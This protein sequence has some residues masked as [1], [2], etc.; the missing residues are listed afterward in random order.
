MN[1]TTERFFDLLVEVTD[2]NYQNMM[3][4]IKEH[5]RKTG[6]LSQKQKDIVVNAVFFR[7]LNA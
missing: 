4:G 5:F 2:P 1:Q 3:I 6:K 7:L